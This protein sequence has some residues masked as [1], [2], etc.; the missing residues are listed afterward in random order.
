MEALQSLALF[1]LSDVVL[2]PQVSVPLFVFEPRYR[3]MTHDVLNTTRQIG[4]IAVRPAAGVD[5]QGDPLL[6]S[7]GC[8]GRITHAEQKPDGTFQILLLG[9]RRFRVVEETPRVGD[10]LYRSARVELLDDVEPKSQDEVAQLKTL[11]LHVLD[12]LKQLVEGSRTDGSPEN[13]LE[14]LSKLESTR[15]IN[16]MAQ[17]ISVDPIERQQLLGVLRQ[18][19]H[20]PGGDLRWRLP[21]RL[22]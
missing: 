18:W 10:R 22:R 15:L 7:V 19:D 2:L 4:M 17:T 1:P 12:E 13:W 3:Q 14:E 8:V 20:R 16:V 5:L 21:R 11:R 9:E 6:F